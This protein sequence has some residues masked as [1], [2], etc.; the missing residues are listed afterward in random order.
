MPYNDLTS[1]QPEAY[2]VGTRIPNMMQV[3]CQTAATRAVVLL[4]LATLPAL[5]QDRLK[6]MPGYERY[7]RMAPQIATALGGNAG[8]Q[9]FGGRGGG[10]VTWA[11]DG[12]SLDYVA[13]GRRMKFDL[14]SK[15]SIETSAIASQQGGRGGGA[16]ARGRQFEFA[17]APAGNH[18]AIYRD[19]N[20]WVGD[21]SG[22]NAVQ[23]TTD[24]SVDK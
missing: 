15:R 8:G 16:P 2:T 3:F 7:A 12:K 24:G 21:S 17:I 6:S 10:G 5:A 11:A 22:A 20:L 1:V 4:T 14:D 18:R 9:I 13:N 19:R 23:I